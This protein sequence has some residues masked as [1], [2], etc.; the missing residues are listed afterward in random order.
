MKFTKK[1]FQVFRKDFEQAM[2]PVAEKY[3]LNITAGNIQYNEDTFSMK[4][5][6][7]KTDAG[8]LAQKEFN[9]Y[10]SLLGFSPEDYGQEFV[11]EGDKYMLAGLSVSS[12][13][14]PCI[15]LR[16]DN[17][18]RYKLTADTVKRLLG[19]EQG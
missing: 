14:Y 9:T 4:V 19:K 11:F 17:Q 2:A 3:A 15:C 7:A 12:P 5:S 6:C 16:L 13:K 1:E 18:K 8:N 10:C